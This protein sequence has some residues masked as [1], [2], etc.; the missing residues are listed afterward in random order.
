MCGIVGYAGRREA[1]PFLIAGLKR[2]E[3]R[4]YDSAGVAVLDRGQVA[5][6]RTAGRIEALEKTLENVSVTGTVGIGHT[7]WA[8]HG[9]PTDINA[10][11]HLGCDGDIAVAHNGIIENHRELKA[12]LLER[13]HTFRS[14]TDTEVIVHLLEEEGSQDLV[15]AVARVAGKLRGTYAIAVVRSGDPERAVATRRDSPLVV[16]VGRDENYFASD[17]PALLARTRQAIVVEDG[18][19]VE[20]TPDAVTIWRDGREVHRPPET[21]PWDLEE[22]ERGGFEHFM[23]KEIMEQ[24]KAI[25]QT[26]AGRVTEDLT[27]LKLDFDLPR[28]PGKVWLVGC[29]TSYHA[30]LVGR[31]LIEK[32]AHV[33]AEA[34]LAS[35]F[36]YLDPLI[37]PA[38]LVVVISQ[39]G[40]TLDT[41]AAL[42][43]ARRTGVPILAI[44]NVIGS[45][46]FREATY[47]LPTRAGPEIAVAS[48]KAYTTQLL[49]LTLLALA[50][51]RMAGRLTKAEER[52]WAEE[53]WG[54][55]EKAD[56]I[57]ERAAEIEDMAHHFQD[58]SSAFFI[59]RGLD[60]AV[61]MEGQLKLKEISYIHAEAL[62]AGELKHGTLALIEPGVPVVA[63]LTQPDLAEKTRSNVAEIRTRGGLIYAVA[64]HDIEG[65][66][67]VEEVFHLPEVAPD[68]APILTVLPLQLLA[69]HVAHLRGEDI[70]K[71]RNLAKSV[72]VE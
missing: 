57:L 37:D 2:L 9:S 6:A 20:I 12:G 14:E 35:E 13:G 26:L 18:E 45:S 47:N 16:G 44:T 72:T 39:S 19:V 49:A 65:G 69:Y 31:R 38:D 51:A 30:A 43:S 27:R 23:L 22:A 64:G 34:E 56:L 32:L 24:P 42:R 28:L 58:A 7:R 66:P 5:L 46:I 71:P 3:Y 70:D 8:T 60:H 1:L 50:L 25:R 55:S 4:G 29:G 41:M 21:V 53:L 67:D 33:P 10:H 62:A 36:R 15:T 59:G 63:L 11:P 54:L 52:T 68:L 61:A 48:S 40:E 17:I